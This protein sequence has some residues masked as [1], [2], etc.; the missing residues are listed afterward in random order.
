MDA[1]AG[2][3]GVKITPKQFYKRK[4][5]LTSEEI[6]ESLTCSDTENMGEYDDNEIDDIGDPEIPDIGSSSEEEEDEDTVVL[7]LDDA[8]IIEAPHPPAKRKR[9]R[10]IIWKQITP[11]IPVFDSEEQS[12]DEVLLTPLQYF[13]KFLSDDFL[14]DIVEQCNLYALQQNPNKPLSLTC[15]EFEQWLGCSF[16]MSVSKIP[17]TRL[18]WSSYTMSDAVSSVMSRNRWEE[19][20]SHLHLVNNNT[21]DK[22]DKLCKV[23]MLVDH[24]KQEF[25]KVPMIEHLSIDEQ[26]VPFKGVSSMK[27]YNPKKPSKWGYKIFVL[28]DDKG[29]VYDFRPYTGKIDPVDKNDVPDL[30]PSA[31]AVLHLAEVIPYHKN[32]KLYF[33][34]WFNSLPLVEYLAT[35]GIWCCGTVQ[36]RRL[37]GLSF[38]SDKQL[39]SKGRGSYDEWVTTNEEGVTTNAIKWYDNK[40]VCLTSTFA[41]SQP[42]QTCVRYDRKRKE[43]VEVPVPSIVKMYNEHMGGVDL[44]DQLLA[45]YRMSFRS[46]KY[47]LRLVFHLFDM[48]VVNSWLVYRRSATSLGIPDKKQHALC[49]FKLKLAYSLTNSGKDLRKKRGRP[50]TDVVKVNFEKKKKCG[51]ATK[52]IP[53]DDVRKD[54]IGHFPAVSANRETCKLPGCKSKVRMHCLKCSVHLCCDQKKNCFLEFHQ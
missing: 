17:N 33:D 52:P 29:Y 5:T 51:R 35:K 45:Y 10:R 48:A 54:G 39:A 21:I 1:V 11:S 7:V 28:A 2:P 23:R 46:R 50:S 53:E 14:K 12:E 3:S 47:Y 26:I 41:T 13:K 34:N 30:G 18:H 37:P 43:Q 31:N 20:K 49:D 38:Q 42:L 27:Q 8:E 4:K 16:F 15:S 36:S 22:T 40:G 19:I 44:Q 9:K 24:L 6:A 25:R 32:H